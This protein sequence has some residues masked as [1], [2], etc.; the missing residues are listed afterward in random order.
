MLPGVLVAL[1]V[2]SAIASSAI[3]PSAVAAQFRQLPMLPNI[4]P[5]ITFPGERNILQADLDRLKARIKTYDGKRSDYRRECAQR[6][7]SNAVRKRRCSFLA[8]EIHRDGSRL[9]T[10]IGALRNRF[11]TVERNALQRGQSGQSGRPVPGA[12]TRTATDDKRPKMIADALAAGRGTWP[13]VL[14]HVKTMLGRGA[15]DPA[16]RDVSAYL[17]GIHSGRMAADRLDNGYY[18]HGI[19]RALSGDYWSAALAFAQAARDTLDDLRVFESF[20]DAAGRQHA[21]PACRRSGRCVSGNMTVWAKR[22]GKRH[23]QPLRQL[24]AAGRKGKLDPAALRMLNILRA[25]TVYS[26]KKDGAPADDPAL[27]AHA[28]QA[29]AAYQNGDRLGTV[30]GYVQLWKASERGRAGLFLYRYGEASDSAA[31]RSLLDFDF[32]SVTALRIDDVY[33]SVLNDAFR[34]GGDASP[35]NGKLSQAQIIRLQR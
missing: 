7:L 10:E 4:P 16:V 25:M 28:A 35:F 1:A 12:A 21:G 19:R 20:A 29:L 6:L 17:T 22:F 9:R 27:Q 15:G 30:T 26:A 2:F 32:P 3:V 34:K 11:G 13:G 8:Q 14:G 31:A 18:K 33:L 5:A 23:V 24:A